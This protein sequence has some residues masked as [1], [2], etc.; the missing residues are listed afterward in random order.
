ME[1]H[2]H[3]TMKV[4]AALCGVAVA[5][6]ASPARADVPD[7]VKGELGLFKKQGG[8]L[9]RV[10]WRDHRAALERLLRACCEHFRVPFDLPPGGRIVT[11]EDDKDFTRERTR[12]ADG[13]KYDHGPKGEAPEPNAQPSHCG[14][15]IGSRVAIDDSI[16]TL[17][18]ASVYP[19]HTG[20]YVQIRERMLRQRIR[21]EIDDLCLILELTYAHV[22]PRGGLGPDWVPTP[23]GHLGTLF[24]DDKWISRDPRFKVK[25]NHV[26]LMVDGIFDKDFYVDQAHNR[27][28]DGKEI[29]DDMAELLR[30]RAE[31]VND[32][33]L[34]RTTGGH[35]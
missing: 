34:T 3:N 6:V 11:G 20:G 10:N 15:D 16:A 14:I 26:H 23:A 27:Q 30:R 9:Q 17:G 7:W 25:G 5:F 31:F 1:R 35:Q 33:L 12:V 18:S 24:G 2:R 13:I 21:C 32:C 19:V 4:L 29:P 8:G 22:Q 28:L